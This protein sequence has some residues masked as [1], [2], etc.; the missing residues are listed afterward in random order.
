MHAGLVVLWHIVECS[1]AEFVQR[2][3]AW[4][5]TFIHYTRDFPEGQVRTVLI[6]SLYEV[7]FW[8]LMEW[9]TPLINVTKHSL[10]FT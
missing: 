9:C 1:C 8:Q 3:A 6:S 4:V 10:T 2:Q 5:S 7:L